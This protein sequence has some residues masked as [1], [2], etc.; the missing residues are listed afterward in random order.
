MTIITHVIIAVC[1]TIIRNNS[2]MSNKTLSFCENGSLKINWHITHRQ[3][4][5]RVAAKPA[6][7]LKL[8]MADLL[9]PK[10]KIWVGSWNVRTLY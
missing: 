2:D 8:S 4:A 9:T 1:L 5:I 3:G 6:W 10:Y 7:Q